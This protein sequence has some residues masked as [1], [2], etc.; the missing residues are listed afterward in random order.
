MHL[1]PIPHSNMRY[2]TLKDLKKAVKTLLASFK[3]DSLSLLLVADI[4]DKAEQARILN[5][6]YECY[7]HQHILHGIVIGM[8]ETEEDFET[9]AVWTHPSTEK[10][11]YS[12]SNLI[13]ANFDDLYKMCDETTRDKIFDGLLPLLHDSYDEIMFTDPRFKKTPCFT[14]VYLG[15]LPK[16]QGKGNVRKMFDFMFSAYITPSSIAYLESSSP[17]NIPIYNRFGFHYY[18]D[19]LL[20]NKFPGA[21]EG[22]DFSIMNVMIRGKDGVDWT[23]QIENESTESKL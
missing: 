18:K 21:I 22:K 12:F 23:K 7:V 1:V 16:A 4:Q 6:F 15:S 9:V 10:A 20:G 13:N 11:L 2:L 8:N 5:K 14:L 17:D 3:T 19:I